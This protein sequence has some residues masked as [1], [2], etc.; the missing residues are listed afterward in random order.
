MSVEDN[1]QLLK[2]ILDRHVHLGVESILSS[3]YVGS[4]LKTLSFYHLANR[5]MMVVQMPITFVLYAQEEG[6][7]RSEHHRTNHHARHQPAISNSLAKVVGDDSKYFFPLW[8]IEGPGKKYFLVALRAD[9]HY[10]FLPLTVIRVVDEIEDLWDAA[11][12][13][14]FHVLESSHYASHGTAFSIFLPPTL[15]NLEKVS[16]AAAMHKPTLDAKLLEKYDQGLLKNTTSYMGLSGLG[17]LDRVFQKINSNIS[18]VSESASRHLSGDK[19]ATNFILFAREYVSNATPGWRHKVYDYDIRILLCSRQR[20]ELEALLRNMKSNKPIHKAL[21]QAELNK[22]G[23]SDKAEGR[24]LF[25]EAEDHFWSL[26]ESEQYATVLDIYGDRFSEH[27]RSMADPA[28]D[29][30]SLYRQPFSRD[31]GLERVF[32]HSDLPQSFDALDTDDPRR[33]DLLRMIICQHF[34]HVFARSEPTDGLILQMMLNP[35]ELGGKVWGVVGFATK[36]FP[37]DKKFDFED[38]SPK[39]VIRLYDK[40]WTKNYHIYRDVNERF[41]KNLRSYMNRYYERFISEIFGTWIKDGQ[42]EESVLLS[43]AM[44]ELNTTLR[45]L[46]C[47]FPYNVVEMKAVRTEGEAFPYPKDVTFPGG[48]ENRRV[49]LARN[50]ALVVN[51]VAES[52]YLPPPGVTV[53]ATSGFV[54][55][56]DVAVAMTDESLKL[57]LV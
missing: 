18:R 52:C 35:I 13:K 2:T 40:V 30:V 21:F 17:A 29:G 33:N 55:A 3:V 42:K 38:S 19:Q 10:Q 39:S 20:A 44:A 14:L 48:F 54:D 34:F 49:L 56:V 26:V 28:F 5:L 4:D 11:A 43:K 57:G 50:L 51:V 45:S 9:S 27:A 46:S 36:S 32:G 23:L 37:Y 15:D 41:K 24:A 6:A 25:N 22:S 1:R 47:V 31:G 16:S 12:Y 7:L 8:D 53:E